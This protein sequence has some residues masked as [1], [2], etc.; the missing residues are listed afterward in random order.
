MRDLHTY[1]RY[2][3]KGISHP[4]VFLVAS[5]V[6]AA[7]DNRLCERTYTDFMIRRMGQTFPAAPAL[8]SDD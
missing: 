7:Q 8:P 1:A 4:D 3:R 6:I 5:E 2:R